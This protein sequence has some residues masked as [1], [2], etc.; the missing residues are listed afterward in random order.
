M[1]VFEM[2][3]ILHIIWLSVS[4]IGGAVSISHKTSHHKILQILEPIRLGVEMVLL[5]WTLA[6]VPQKLKS[7]RKIKVWNTDLVV[8]HWNFVIWDKTSW[9]VSIRKM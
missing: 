8:F 7:F 6:A 9:W 4:Y 5:F 2:D 1:V 3:G